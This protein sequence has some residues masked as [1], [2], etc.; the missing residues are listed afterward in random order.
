[1]FAGIPTTAGL[2]EELRKRVKFVGDQLESPMARFF[3]S[4]V[5]DE[6]DP[7]DVEDLYDSVDRMLEAEETHRLVTKCKTKGWS[8]TKRQLVTVGSHSDISR[9]PSLKS[10]ID[11]ADDIDDTIMA[12]KSIKSAIRDMLLEKCMVDK[13]KRDEVKAV[14]D[15]VLEPLGIRDVLTTNYDNVIETYCEEARMPLAN[16]FERSFHGDRREW[17]GKFEGVGSGALR[18]VKMHGSVTWQRD[19]DAVLELGRPG[20]RGEKYDVMIY[21]E[22]GPKMY[23]EI[24]F[25]ELELRFREVLTDTDLLVVVGYSFRDEGISRM[26]KQ[27]LAAKRQKGEMTL[28]YV[29]PKPDPGMNNLFGRDISK[30]EQFSRYPLWTYSV[31]RISDVYAYA[32]RFNRE[33]SPTVRSVVNTVLPG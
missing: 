5:L 2:V 30:R 29:D 11:E 19:G 1:M 22:K 12:L 7:K 32:T 3:T 33:R 6:T 23:D 8:G 15:E 9:G 27:R 17:T 16:G 25:S 21:P 4:N 26:I 24:I 13:K 31:K 10:P 14:Y 18:L 28:L 20:A